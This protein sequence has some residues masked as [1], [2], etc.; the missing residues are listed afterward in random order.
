MNRKSGKSGKANEI[1][2]DVEG[3]A[4]LLGVSR[5][6]VY[7]LISKDKLPTTKVGRE[8]RFHRPTLIQWVATG[9][10]A[11]QLERIFK[12]ANIKKK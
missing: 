4:A 5:H 9:S 6:T 1:I 7:R 11:S 10:S 2:L 3:A 12:N 8:W